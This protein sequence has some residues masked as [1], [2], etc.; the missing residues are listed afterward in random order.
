ME[1]YI[2]S[3]K[4]EFGVTKQPT[5]NIERKNRLNDIDIVTCCDQI[6]NYSGPS[7]YHME[8]CRIYGYGFINWLEYIEFLPEGKGVIVAE[9]NVFDDLISLDGYYLEEEILRPVRKD[10]FILVE[11]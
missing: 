2:G 1:K 9:T 11:E 6:E 3:Q 7:N 10:E 8:P 4:Q 5:P